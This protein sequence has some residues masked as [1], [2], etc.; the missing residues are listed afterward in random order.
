MSA[1][2]PVFS[3]NIISSSAADRFSLRPPRFDRAAALTSLY[4]GP[5][6]RASVLVL[7]VAELYPYSMLL[8]SA[9]DG[10][11]FLPMHHASPVDAYYFLI[12]GRRTTSIP[13]C[14]WEYTLPTSTHPRFCSTQRSSCI[15]F[16]QW[17]NFGQWKLMLD[18]YS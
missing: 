5:G 6:T 14:T 4:V 9:F 16:P 7:L 11:L 15:H 17:S 12:D 13:R 10:H 8:P 1:F 18:S 3:L 2:S